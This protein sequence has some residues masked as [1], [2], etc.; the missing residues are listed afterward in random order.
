[1]TPMPNTPDLAAAPPADATAAAPAYHLAQLNIARLRAPL[2]SPQLVDFV[3]GLAPINR[4]A[5]S[6]AGFVWRL[7]GDEAN[8]DATYVP[9]VFDADILVNLSVWE[10]V[11]SLW[12]FAYRTEHL[13]YLRRRSEWFAEIEERFQVLW[14]VPV[15][16][17]P[18]ER[19][20]ADRL[21]LLRAQGP[22]PDAFTFRQ[23]HP[24]PAA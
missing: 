1:M 23:R 15:G 17:R 20:A 8:P 4:L 24:A 21:E 19:D 6:S 10:D 14:W 13:E 16:T 11:D 5:E 2:D 12:N 9:A 7:V 18:T 3:A 22:G